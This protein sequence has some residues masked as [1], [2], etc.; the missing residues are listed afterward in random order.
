MS[1]ESIDTAMTPQQRQFA[2]G[3]EASALST[4]KQVMVGERSWASF[5]AFELYRLCF[6]GME[7]ILGVGCRRLTLPLFLSACGNGP[8][9]GHGVT[10]RQPHRISFGKKVILDDFSAVDVRS[11]PGKDP[12][13]GISLGD[14]TYVGRYS[15]VTAKYGVIQLGRACNIGSYSRIAT[16]DKIEIGASV[17]IASYVYIGP[18]NH[19][20][21]DLQTPVMEQEME[22]KGG[23]RIGDNSWIGTK[24]TILD[25]VSIGRDA[26]VG[27]HSLVREDVPDRAIVAGAPAKI[28]RYRE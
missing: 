4:Y 14:Y 3:S 17:L 6:A 27:A 1:D 25:G 24:A 28:I 18:G 20:A 13:A 22:S 21:D 2:S 8:V 11:R 12:Q 23:V 10:I 15:I 19:G 7:S 9:I 26:I 5:T 16:R